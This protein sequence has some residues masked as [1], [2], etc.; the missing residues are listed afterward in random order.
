MSCFWFEA[1]R[2]VQKDRTVSLNGVVYEVE[3]HLVGERVTLR[4][5][6]AAPPGRAIQVWH[7]ARQVQ[8]AKPLD[9]YA[10]AFVKRHRPSRNL[11]PDA[12]PPTPA[13]G[14]ALR[15]LRDRDRRDGDDNKHG[16]D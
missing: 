12:P 4:Y 11:L 2:K 13:P 8:E 5:D 6:P 10:N 3:P 16:E 9:A 14:L 1:P 7:D 15:K